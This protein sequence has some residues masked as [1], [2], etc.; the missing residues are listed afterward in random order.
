MAE[1]LGIP[2]LGA[3]PIDPEVGQTGDEGRP[4]LFRELGFGA[5]KAF[6]P[7]LRSQV[8]TLKAEAHE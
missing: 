3:L 5:R 2:F 1:E 8:R 4:Q 7:V 6:Q